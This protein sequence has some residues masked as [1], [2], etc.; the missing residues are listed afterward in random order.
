MEPCSLLFHPIALL[1]P[2]FVQGTSRAN[3]I[4]HPLLQFDICS[5]YRFTMHVGRITVHTHSTATICARWSFF[6]FIDEMFFRQN[7]ELFV[8]HVWPSY[9]DDDELQDLLKLVQVA[10]PQNSMQSERSYCSKCSWIGRE[11]TIFASSSPGFS[12]FVI[13]F[14]NAKCIS[15]YYS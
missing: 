9:F 10:S 3:R 7:A 2:F 8:T 4:F 15:L 12:R 1:L 13:G 6:L 14:G 5:W 11:V